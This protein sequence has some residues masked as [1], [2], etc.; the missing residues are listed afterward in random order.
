[1]S[2]QDYL[3]LAEFYEQCFN[4]YGTTAKGVDWPN[5]DDMTK[6]F[7]VMLAICRQDSSSHIELLDLGCG[8]GALL[9]YLHQAQLDERIAYTGV[10]ISPVFITAAKALHPT[11]TF[12]QCDILKNPL[13]KMDY[14]YVIMNGVFTEKRQLSHASMVQFVKQMLQQAFKMARK[15]IAFNI[16]SYH[17]DWSNL[18]L[19][20]WSLDELGMFL[21]QEL[22]RQFVIRQ[23]YG[24]YEYTVYVYKT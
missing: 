18:D 2:T 14:D 9:D 11:A 1:M 19:F 8:Y 3:K 12:Y 15:G 22:S 13:P 20:H 17:V 24:L 4:Q 5:S 10:D 23:D 7:Q 21:T 16:M 6:R